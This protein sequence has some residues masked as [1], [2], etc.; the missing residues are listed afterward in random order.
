MNY[1]AVYERQCKISTHYAAV[2]RKGL[3]HICQN[4]S[5]ALL[6]PDN[7]EKWEIPT[8]RN[9]HPCSDYAYYSTVW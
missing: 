9:R 3:S 5:D 2:K 6:A 4:R 8:F 7:K 1:Q